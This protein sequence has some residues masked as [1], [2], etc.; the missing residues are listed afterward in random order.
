MRQLALR[1][2]KKFTAFV[3]N[4]KACHAWKDAIASSL[5]WHSAGQQWVLHSCP[6]HRTCPCVQGCFSPLYFHND[7]N[8][9]CTNLRTVWS[10]TTFPTFVNMGAWS[11]CSKHLYLRMHLQADREVLRESTEEYASQSELQTIL[12][13]YPGMLFCLSTTPSWESCSY[14]S[15]CDV[16]YVYPPHI[17]VAMLLKAWNIPNMSSRKSL[18]FT[19][20]HKQLLRRCLLL[21]SL[22]LL[23]APWSSWS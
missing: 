3:T 12:P 13:P 20:K 2:C 1:V 6:D 7:C 19:V 16:Q 15:I 23:L 11:T 8:D 18:C 22:V 21:Y 4:K 5:H 10:T 9:C 17:N 14:L